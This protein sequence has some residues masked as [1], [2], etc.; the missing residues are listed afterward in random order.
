MSHKI[1][2]ILLVVCLAGLPV[3]AEAQVVRPP[4]IK[5]EFHRAQ[6]AFRTGSSSYEAKTRLDRVIAVLPDDA[7][8]R[9]LRAKVLLDLGRPEQALSDA[10]FAVQLE[11][12]DGEAHLLLSETF[13]AA[14]FLEESKE[15]LNTAA[16][17]I[18]DDADL[19]IRLSFNAEMLGN[20]DQ[21]EA[22]ARLAYALDGTLPGAVRQLARV[23]VAMDRQESAAMLLTLAL[24]AGVLAPGQLISDPRLAVLA[25]RPELERWFH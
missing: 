12:S 24:E 23:F 11:P 7:E 5:L 17:L 19:H 4:D 6:R 10:R 21:A 3:E 22:Y 13:R 16:S 20:L 8:A 2:L 18:T 15:A 25:S 14:G 9:L 1:A